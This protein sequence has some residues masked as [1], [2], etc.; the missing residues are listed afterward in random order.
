MLGQTKKTRYGAVIKE[1][2]A[3][4]NCIFQSP[5]PQLITPITPAKL[6]KKLLGFQSLR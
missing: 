2:E 1:V 3:D 6:C 4:G 5:G